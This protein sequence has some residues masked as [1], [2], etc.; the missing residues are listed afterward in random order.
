VRQ[1]GCTIAALLALA[2]ST[3]ISVRTAHLVLV[4]GGPT[5]SQVFERTLS[6]SGGQRS[7]V[8]V[9]PQTYPVDT[10]ADAAVAMWRTF[11][12]RDVVKV[13]R[14]D[15]SAARA[16]LER[17]TLIWMPGGFQGLLMRTIG[18]TPIPQILRARFAAGVTI[19]GASAGAAAMSRTMIADESAPDGHGIDGPVTAEGLGLWPEA[20]VSPHFTERRRLNALM[21][22]VADHPALIGV[23]L[24]EG[25]AVIVS[26]GEFEVMGR[27]TVVIVD[28]RIPQVRTLK[29]GMR[30]RFASR[31]GRDR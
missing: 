4:G 5:P 6:F 1:V 13:S 16:A 7:I 15:S 21:P 20:I 17:A 19:G 10:I 31:S 18:G 27:G 3:L 30:F 26:A 2:T 14:D 24:D 9:L 28:A 11:G 22:I 8:A 23:G 12:V 25:T 29:A